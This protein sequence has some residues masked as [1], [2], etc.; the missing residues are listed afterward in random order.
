MPLI[1]L[2]DQRDDRA[3]H[4]IRTDPLPGEL[5]GYMPPGQEGANHK[6]VAASRNTVRN[7]IFPSV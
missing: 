4:S 6:P 2:N 7:F 5:Y 3:S 1:S